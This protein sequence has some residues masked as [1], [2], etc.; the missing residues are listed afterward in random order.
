M[1]A[2]VGYDCKSY[3]VLLSAAMK[4]ARLSFCSCYQHH[5]GRM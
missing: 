3:Y 5:V 1:N 4:G 2:V